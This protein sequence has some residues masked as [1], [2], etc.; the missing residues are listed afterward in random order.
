MKCHHPDVFLR[1][2]PERAADGVLRAGAIGARCAR[3]WRRGPAGRREPLGLGLH[4]GADSTASLR[5]CALACAWSRGLA[6][7]TVASIVVSARRGA[8]LRSSIEDVWRRAA[9]PS[10]LAC[11]GSPRP[12]PFARSAWRAAKRSGRSRP[13][14]TKPLPLFAAADDA[15]RLRPEVSRAAVAL[16]PM[17]PGREVVED[18]RSK[19]LSLRAHPVAFL[20]DEPASAAI[21]P[22]ADLRT[23]PDGQRV[24]RG[25]PCA[26]AADARLRQGRHVHHAGGRDRHRQSASSGPTVFEQQRRTILS[27][28]DDGLPR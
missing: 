16:R 8:S 24:D 21:V 7:R 20:R 18:Y 28:G 14:A 22:C 1:R 26:G 15:R 5:A 6:A 2:D 10:P 12:M 27:C 4:A 3:A 19:G 23:A 25:R 13:C 9:V 11:R 17:T